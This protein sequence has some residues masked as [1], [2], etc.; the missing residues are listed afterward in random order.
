AAHGASTGDGR[1][2]RV[3]RQLG[4]LP[5]STD[6]PERP[7]DVDDCS[8]APVVDGA[9]RTRHG[10]GQLDD[11]LSAHGVAGCGCAV[12]GPTPVRARHFDVRTYRTLDGL[13][14]THYGKGHCI[15]GTSS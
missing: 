12:R 11:G 13:R 1:R 14:P 7:G 4:R 3:Y 5:L 10:L 6:L 2:I 9:R 8:R 15:G